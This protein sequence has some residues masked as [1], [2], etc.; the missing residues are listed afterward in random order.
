MIPILYDSNEVN[1]TSN[2]LGRLR[3]C[4]EA[5]VVEERNGIYEMDFS[6]PV[7]GENYD[8][9][10]LGRIIGVTHEDSD[11]IQPF[12]IVSCSRPIGGVVTFHCTHISYRQSKMV[13]YGTSVST[14]TGAFRIFEQVFYPEKPLGYTSSGNPFVYETDKSGTAYIP[15]FDGTPRTIRSILGGVEGSILDTFGGEYEWDKWNVILHTARGEAKNFSIRYGVNLIDFQ[16]DTDYGESFNTCV[17]FWKSTEGEVVMGGEISS[18]E[19]TVG[20]GDKCVPLDL[21]DKFEEQPTVADLEA[22]AADIMDAN[23]PYLPKQNIKVDFVR[24]QDEAG[25]DQFDSLL[26]CKLCDSIKVIFPRY[27]MSAYFKIVKT[28]W[29]VLLD[30]YDG[31]E[32]GNLSTTLAEALGVTNSGGFGGSGESGGTWT[33]LGSSSGANAITYSDVETAGYKEIY[34]E[35]NEYCGGYV[36]VQSLP[37]TVLWGAYYMGSYGAIRQ[38]SVT[39]TAM[40]PQ[41]CYTNGQNVMSGTSW[42]VYAR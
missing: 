2:G 32:L 5:K 6:Y 28:T 8:L 31:M 19:S 33:L 30:R 41:I 12:D 20:V 24:L 42:K 36:L 15:A 40:T 13:T 14:L 3:S 21:S 34:I 18:G 37:K 26:Q 29:N 11:D 25:F 7:D 23:Q 39:K 22:M 38:V 27:D 35:N 16:D 4:I 1:F 10:Q 17:P 9:I